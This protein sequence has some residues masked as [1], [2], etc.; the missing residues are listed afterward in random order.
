MKR[1]LIAGAALS[2]AA[3]S[4]TYEGSDNNGWIV[5]GNWQY[6]YQKDELR[7]RVNIKAYNV[8]DDY[9]KIYVESNSFADREDYYAII[10]PACSQNRTISVRIDKGEVFTFL[11]EDY[12]TEARVYLDSE[13]G[14]EFIAANQVVVEYGSTYNPGQ[15]TFN[16][17][18]LDLTPPAEYQ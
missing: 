3:C 9:N 13:I 11:C 1:V 10:I 14:K 12:A 5:K 2:L 7:D 17:S 18:G 8:I 16:T 15:V 4:N 6:M